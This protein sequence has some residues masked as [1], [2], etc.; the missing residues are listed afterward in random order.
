MILNFLNIAQVRNIS[1]AE[2]EISPHFNLF[3]GLNGSGKTSILE[4]LFLLTHGRSFRTRKMDRVIQSGK[5]ELWVRG[6][7]GDPQ[8]PSLTMGVKRGLDGTVQFKLGQED[9][10][11]C[12]ELA[13]QYPLLLI[14]PDSYRLL[15]MGPFYRRQF[16][17]WGLFHVEHEFH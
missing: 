11:Q 1:Q 4:S 14:N 8:G 6:V 17:D 12:G 3:Y 2:G 10:K 13:R 15:E 9:I 7:L 16:M 5:E